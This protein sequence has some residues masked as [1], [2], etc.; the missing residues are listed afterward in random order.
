LVTSSQFQQKSNNNTNNKV[1]KQ[2]PL[3]FTQEVIEDYYNK[4]PQ[5]TKW[6]EAILNSLKG[7]SGE[8]ALNYLD[9]VDPVDENQLRRIFP[10]ASPT[11]MEDPLSTVTKT[12]LHD[13]VRRDPSTQ[14][15]VF[16]IVSFLLG[17]EIT[18]TFEP[19]RKFAT[20]ERREREMKAIQ[21]NEQ[22]LDILEDLMNRDEDVEL[23]TRLA[24]LAFSAE[25]FGRA[26]QIK[27]YNRKGFPCKL[28]PLASTRLGHVW[29]DRKT[30]DFLGVE[31]LD[32]PRSQRI[33]LAK[34]I[35]HY[36]AND[37]HIT[38]NSRYFGMPTIESTMSIAERNRAA[39]EKAIP[40][41]MAKM[42]AGTNIYKILG[43]HSDEKIRE[44]MTKV[45][46]GKD[47]YVNEE[48][49]VQQ[50]ELKH[51]LDKIVNAVLEGS[52]D[53]YRGTTIPQTVAFQD[54][55]NR[56]TAEGQMIQ[57]YESVLEFKRNQLNTVFWNQYYKPQLESIFETRD[58]NRAAEN[59]S[60]LQYLE[61]RAKT[62][63]DMADQGEEYRSPIPFKV[64]FEFGDIRTT[65][66][67]D[68]AS[69]L[70][71]FGDRHYLEPYMVREESGL[72]RWNNDME[73][74]EFKRA[75]FNKQQFGVADPSLLPQG[76]QPWNNQMEEGGGEGS[77]EQQSD[78]KKK[79]GKFGRPGSFPMK[80]N[81]NMPPNKPVGK[82][83]FGK[84]KGGK[85]PTRQNSE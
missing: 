12:R 8:Q 78:D 74:V 3:L 33:L 43:A 16:F 63:D 61:T 47:L 57:W 80:A 23:Q 49:E 82:G 77:N 55:T 69:A 58:M 81:P 60:V 67:L 39:N 73:E 24:E 52:K 41:I 44:I 29:V 30:W 56:A 25:A 46:P 72:G 51:D 42:W 34:D 59:G 19:A 85:L 65:G 75:L 10:N 1:V 48:I 7:A 5:K 13:N 2:K 27:K 50:V 68:T 9:K 71:Q 20:E 76:Y 28:I 45:R 70:L 15:A 84:V 11:Q 35:I 62:I 36:E 4:A 31:Y 40:E 66:F 32:Y 21:N 38:P 37:F 17:K 54:L 26:V 79:K 6:S 14:R 64:K 53:I 18:L 83:G 22:Y